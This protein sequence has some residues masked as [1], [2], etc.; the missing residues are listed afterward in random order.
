MK[1]SLVIKQNTGSSFQSFNGKRI[2]SRCIY[3]ESLP[4]ITFDENGI[5]N[6]CHMIDSLIEE[7]QTGK[8]EGEKD[9]GNCR[10]NKK[11]WQ[12]KKI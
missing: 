11:G 3:D 4:S 10:E 7:Y 8:P 2:C 6:Y 5:C 1:D 9:I 12:K